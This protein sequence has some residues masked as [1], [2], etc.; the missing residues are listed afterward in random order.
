[1]TDAEYLRDVA[2]RSVTPGSTAERLLAIADRI[3]AA[4]AEKMK[5]ITELA[6]HEARM[7][8]TQHVAER[9]RRFGEHY[10]VAPLKSD[11]DPHREQCAACGM[12]LRDPIH[13]R[14]AMKAKP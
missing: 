7:K 9:Y 1:M 11:D 3:E 8:D 5:V 13:K 4:E 2:R 14:V 6:T 10:H 12:N